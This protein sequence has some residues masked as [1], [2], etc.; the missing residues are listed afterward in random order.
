MK[1]LTSKRKGK[2][3]KQLQNVILLTLEGNDYLFSGFFCG[4]VGCRAFFFNFL[5]NYTF[6]FAYVQPLMKSND[7]GF[8]WKEFPVEIIHWFLH[9]LTS[10]HLYRQACR[11]AGASVYI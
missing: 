6:A 5:W 11:G 3:K 4:T 10:L 1:L 9:T 8:D 7:D 2:K